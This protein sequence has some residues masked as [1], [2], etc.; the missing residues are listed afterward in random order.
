MFFS[1]MN[2]SRCS[3]GGMAQDMQ[4]KGWVL[5]CSAYPRSDA[6]IKINEQINMFG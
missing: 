1:Y 6:T 3:G 2:H 5:I 4:D